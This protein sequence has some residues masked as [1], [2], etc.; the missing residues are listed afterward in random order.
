MLPLIG[1]HGEV[2]PA[3]SSLRC[4]LV[5]QAL[6]GTENPATTLLC[7]VLKEYKTVGGFCMVTLSRETRGTVLPLCSS[8]LVRILVVK[9]LELDPERGRG[10]GLSWGKGALRGSLFIFESPGCHGIRGRRLQM[11]TEQGVVGP[12]QCCRS[13]LSTSGLLTYLAACRMAAFGVQRGAVSL[14]LTSFLSYFSPRMPWTSEGK[15]GH[16]HPTEPRQSRVLLGVL[17]EA[18]SPCPMQLSF[19]AP[20]R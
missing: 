4:S 15:L 18:Y 19:G 14:C 16:S 12:T 8:M 10:H 6:C 2:P 20:R 7:F 1:I 3:S 5:Y 11:C 9:C 17:I 13:W